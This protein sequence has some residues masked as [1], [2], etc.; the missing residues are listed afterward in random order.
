M[1]QGMSILRAPVDIKD[2][3]EAK[4]LVVTEGQI[5]FEKVQFKYKDALPFF[6]K[7]LWL[8]VHEKSWTCWI[9]WIWKV[10]I[11]ESD[12]AFI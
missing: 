1:M 8:F 2:D 7:S 11:R 3:V 12:F 5:V 4:P 9:L 10:N 6:M